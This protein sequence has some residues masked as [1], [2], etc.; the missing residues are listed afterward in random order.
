MFELVD[1]VRRHSGRLLDLAGLRTGEAPHRPIAGFKGARVHAYAPANAGGPVLLI[2]AAPFKRPYIWDL[3]PAVSVV[4][5]CL[6]GGIRPYLLEWTI[7]GHDED[8]LG[9]DDYADRLIGAAV[10]AA[11]ADA[12]S[13]EPLLAGHSLGGTLAAIFAS[14]HPDQVAGLVLLD[15]PLGFGEPDDPLSRAIATLPSWHWIRDIF[16][17]PVPGSAINLLCSLAAPDIFM[18]HP[19]SDYLASL[20]NPLAMAIHLRVRR[21]T[22]D[23]F[24]IPGRLFDETVESLYREDR[25]L[26]GCLDMGAKRTGVERLRGRLL[27]VVNPAGGIVPPNS[28][29]S[30]LDRLSPQVS[31]HVLAYQPDCGPLLQHLGPLV[32]PAAHRLLWPEIIRWIRW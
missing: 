18:G 29:L 26:R 16:G 9:L 25:F 4:R 27:A 31:A 17:S 30:A 6:E 15:A 23:E 3:L 13:A 20:S 19:V 7:P 21:W 32:A 12:R 28:M 24:P 14:L 1:E 2:I 22:L 5:R 11:R 10:E 8:Q